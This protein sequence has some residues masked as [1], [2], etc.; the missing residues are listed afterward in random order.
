MQDAHGTT[1]SIASLPHAA[2]RKLAV[3]RVV[4]VAVAVV[5]YVLDRWT[6]AWALDNL[7][8]GPGESWLNGWLRLQLVLNPGA[9]FS[10][11]S[12][13]TIVFTVLSSI[14]LVAV[15]IWGWPRVNSWLT[16]FVG[17]AVVCGIT[18]NLTDRLIRP[19]GV[20][21][22]EV[23]DFISV[24]HFAVF[25]VAD[26]FITCAAIGLAIH[27]LRA[28]R[29]ERPSAGSATDDTESTDAP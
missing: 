2:R 29:S 13:V 4:M 22:G 11:G 15:F 9:A 3:M 10:M 25:N 7:S 1:L 12:S 27:L 28:E 6:K 23:V 18:G 16:A 24:Q 5:G 20:L 14:A 17:G 8:G 19:P 26:I 21:R